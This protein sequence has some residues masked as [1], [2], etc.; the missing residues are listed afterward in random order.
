MKGYLALLTTI[1]FLAILA[2]LSL[3]YMQAGDNPAIL[4]LFGTLA[5]GWGAV[6]GYYF[7]SAE[8]AVRA[9][10]RKSDTEGE[11]K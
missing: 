7:G 10:Q 11:V 3:G 4:I 1:G 5:S 6:I 9:P 8:S 2:G